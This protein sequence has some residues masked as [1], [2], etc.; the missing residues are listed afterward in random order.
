MRG[1][2]EM[3]EEQRVVGIVATRR[4]LQR[5]RRHFRPDHVRGVDDRRVSNGETAREVQLRDIVMVDEEDTPDFVQDLEDDAPLRRTIGLCR[6]PT[7]AGD[8]RRIPIARDTHAEMGTELDGRPLRA[9]MH[10][11]STVRSVHRL[12]EIDRNGGSL[13]SGTSQEQSGE[14]T[15]LPCQ[16]TEDLSNRM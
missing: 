13:W 7:G 1:G 11:A 5:P 9:S 10:H 6:A 4:R 14:E 12:Y 2:E 3:D 15:H 8:H 16:T